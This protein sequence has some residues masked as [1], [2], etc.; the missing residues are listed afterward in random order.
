MSKVLADPGEV[1]DE[2]P[3]V[4]R[5]ALIQALE[6]YVPGNS[7]AQYGSKPW[8]VVP[9]IL[10]EELTP[11]LVDN[12]EAVPLSKDL[13]ALPKDTDSSDRS[14]R[15]G[16]SS[17]KPIYRASMAGHCV[18][19]LMLWRIGVGKQ[20]QHRDE[21]YETEDA[22]VLG[23]REGTLHEGWIIESLVEQGYEVAW[24]G[25][26]QQ[27]EL[28][29]RYKRYVVRSHPDGM[30]RG[31]ELGEEWHVLEC[32]ALKQERYLLW[33]STGW[34]AFI[35]YAHQVSLEMDLSGR[36]GFF[37]VKN[38]NTGQIVKQI[39]ETPPIDPKSIYRKYTRIENLIEAAAEGEEPQLPECGPNAEWF[40]CPFFSLGKCDIL[41]GE[42]AGE[43]D[44]IEDEKFSEII[45]EYKGAKKIIKEA[46]AVVEALRTAIVDRMVSTRLK[47][48]DYFSSYSERERKG[49]N[50]PLAKDDLQKH[51]EDT[52]K[53][54]KISKYMELRITGGPKDGEE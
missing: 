48:G 42:E 20:L 23:A 6:S 2:M 24:T 37:V 16:W 15:L 33:L 31:K 17:G 14:I 41:H 28:E 46:E 5:V 19:E 52:S 27:I 44:E 29:R 12:P 38:R 54:D 7:T 3:V 13:V 36:K 11:L 26:G 34:D 32:K 1:W 51:G 9:E 30:I 39:I 49:F 21:T 45:A 50:I 4:A 40:W 8:A 18:K 47:V 25:N 22:G 53:Y 10:Q 43:I 35:G